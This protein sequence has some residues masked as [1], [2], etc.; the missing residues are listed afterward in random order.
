MTEPAA[1]SR[2]TLYDRL[3]ERVARWL[4]VPP[5]PAVPAGS[6]GSVRWFQAA[7]GFYRYRVVQRLV[8]QAG[9]LW[10]LVAG[11]AFVGFVPDE[12][13]FSENFVWLEIAG[14]VAFVLQ[15]PL[16]FFLVRLD[17]E[18]RWYLVTDR[19][20]RIREGVWKVHE[21]T[22]SFANVQNLSVRQGPV[23]RFFGISD[24]QVRSAGGGGKGDGGKGDDGEKKDLHLAFFRGVSN[25][26]EIRDLI[27]VH[28]RGLRGSGLGDPEDEVEEAA[29]PRA[30]A[31]GPP[32]ADAVAAARELLA[33]ASA[34]RTA[35]ASAPR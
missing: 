16:S 10:G 28:L 31:A 26:E 14:I 9:A 2:R 23:Q 20:L 17:F 21:Q 34:L 3:E 15:L 27:L 25:A 1:A 24:L 19:S 30:V 22:M 35:L 18:K 7:P 29:R 12:I 5:R 13:P 33:E 6:P 4:R 8:K 32:D 11:L